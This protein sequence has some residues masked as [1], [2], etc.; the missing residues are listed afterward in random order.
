MT[1]FFVPENEIIDSTKEHISPS[2]NYKLVVSSFKTGANSWNYTQGKVYK[3]GSDEP[4]AVIQRN[5]SSFPF[6]F[7]ENHPKGEFLLCGKDY[8]G[9]TIIELT[10]GNVKDCMSNGSD[11]GVGFC[12]ASYEYNPQYNILVVD[13]CIWACPYEYRL[14]DFSDPM[15]GIKEIYCDSML[16]SNDCGKL[17]FKDNN[18]VEH[19]E[20]EYNEDDDEYNG[21]LTIKTTF[22]LQDGKLLLLEEWLSDKEK[23]SRK[24]REEHKI[25][26]DQWYDNFK[27]NDPLYL[28]MLEHLK[29]K[30][31]ATAHTYNS[32]GYTYKDWCNDPAISENR[33]CRRIVSINKLFKKLTIDLEFGV[34]KGPIKLIIF[35][36][37]KSG[38]PMFFEHS[39]KG[40]NEAMRY[41]KG[42]V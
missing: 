22:K 34:E 38:K 41:A 42:L 17:I 25:K 15:D 16:Y 11:K 36:N 37:H 23:Q 5:Y 28:Q 39:I 26:F 8:Q 14:F 3:V 33:L 24:E 9:Q 1:N 32:I 6:L 40:M 12:W 20:Y 7:I 18:I 27:A 31:F 30:A 29:D 10:T 19:S 35:K 13:G 4:I 2:G 21:P